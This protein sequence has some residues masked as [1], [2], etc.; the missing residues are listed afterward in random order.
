MKNPWPIALTVLCVSAFAFATWI[1]VTMIRQKVELVTPDYYAQDLKHEERMAQQQRA[2]E[3]ENPLRV[4][5]QASSQSV[6]VKLP[7]PQATGTIHLYRPSD[8]KLDRRFDIAPDASGVQTL[9]ADDLASGPWQVIIAWHQ[10]D[11]S[12][13]Q[14][15]SLVIP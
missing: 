13:Y 9:P 4:E 12:Y 2:R 7:S 14:T 6:V 15:E 8:S 5:W 1:A 3:L 10:N 11:S